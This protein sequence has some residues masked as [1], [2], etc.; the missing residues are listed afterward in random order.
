MHMPKVTNLFEQAIEVNM[1]HASRISVQ[2][3]VLAMPI[4]ESTIR[5]LELVL[6][7]LLASYPK[8]KPIMDM[9]AALLVYT[10]RL[11][12]HVDGSGKVSINHSWNTGGNLRVSSQERPCAKQFGLTSGGLHSQISHRHRHRLPS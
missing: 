3:D 9:T 12:S 6:R 5:N 1:N 2:Q 11:V 4:P 7:Q 10:R 8:I